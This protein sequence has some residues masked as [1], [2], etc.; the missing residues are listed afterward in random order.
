MRQVVP[1]FVDI[2]NHGAGSSAS[3]IIEAWLNP[4][5]VLTHMA[6]VGTTSCLATITLP[7]VSHELNCRVL[8]VLSDTIS[9][10][11]RQQD[12][13]VLRGI[14]LE[15]PV[16]TTLGGLPESSKYVAQDEFLQ[17][18]DMAQPGL[19]MMTISPSLASKHD[20]WHIHQ[21]LAR[22]IK[23]ALGHDLE[24][25]MDVILGISLTVFM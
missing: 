20:Y 25:T 6:H 10:A 15:G 13:A 19:K 1:G 23:P 18:L 7:S 14:H 24:A 8:H 12:A 3:D 16:I 9:K 22:G 4:Q 17:L 2:H 21:L 5:E 11:T